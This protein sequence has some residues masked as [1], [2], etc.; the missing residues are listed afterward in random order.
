V[1][2]G[3]GHVLASAARVV[4]TTSES[5]DSGLL[6]EVPENSAPAL[7]A[8]SEQGSLSATLLGNEGG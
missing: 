3:Q 5:P 2:E 6:V 8:A 7:A 4:V 1:V